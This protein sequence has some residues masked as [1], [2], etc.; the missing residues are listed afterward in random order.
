MKYG[1]LTKILMNDNTTKYICMIDK[2]DVLFGNTVVRETPN[3]TLSKANKIKY[4]GETIII[5]P[6]LTI[7]NNIIDILNL[8]PIEINNH[9]LYD[10]GNITPII[11]I[12]DELV[13]LV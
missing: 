13:T 3:K 12:K 7:I 8:S 10:L 4:K 9:I 1:P 11:V 5:S 6:A 2:G